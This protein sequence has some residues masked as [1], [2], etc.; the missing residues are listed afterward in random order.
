MGSWK[1]AGNL[2]I[3]KGSRQYVVHLSSPFLTKNIPH[4]SLEADF[5]GNSGA[6]SLALTC[7]WLA[8]MLMW[9]FSI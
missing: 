9:P 3:W 2:G 4:P 5:A 6:S 7:F 8:T 1:D